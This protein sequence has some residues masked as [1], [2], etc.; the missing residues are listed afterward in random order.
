MNDSNNF[1]NMHAQMILFVWIK[2]T[3]NVGGAIITTILQFVEYYGI[4][5]MSQ[6]VCRCRLM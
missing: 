2:P 6:R 4:N 3:Q 5:I 1:E